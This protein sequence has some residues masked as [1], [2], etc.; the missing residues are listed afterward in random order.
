MA[1]VES[2][3]TRLPKTRYCRS[4]MTTGSGQT[5]SPSRSHWLWK[6]GTRE[7]SLVSKMWSR[8]PVM[9]RKSSLLQMISSESGWKMT[10]G[11]GE[12]IMVRRE[13]ASTPRVMLSR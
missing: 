1:D 11:R 5:W 8:S 6:A 2:V 4:P 13:A 9:W 12:E 3:F 7:V 10:M